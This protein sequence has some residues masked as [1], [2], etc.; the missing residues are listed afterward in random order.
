MTWFLAL[1]LL[2]WVQ[3]RPW[4]DTRGNWRNDLKRHWME[5]PWVTRCGMEMVEDDWTDGGRRGDLTPGQR[6]FGAC[7]KCLS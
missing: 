4:D 3:R 7:K 2:Q 1:L 5:R 6:E